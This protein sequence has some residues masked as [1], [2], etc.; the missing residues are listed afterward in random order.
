MNVDGELYGEARLIE[1]VQETIKAG[2]K[3]LVT[4]LVD[5]VHEFSKGIPQS[6]D[7]TCLVIRY[8]GPSKYQG[9]PS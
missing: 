1:F 4:T 8:D 3:D 6:D 5:S 7:I 9:T 2:D